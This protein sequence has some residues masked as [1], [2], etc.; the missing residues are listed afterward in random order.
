M[1]RHLLRFTSS[2]LFFLLTIT[3]ISA[4][5]AVVEVALFY[6]PTCPH[7]HDIID[8]YLPPLQERY[9]DALRIYYINVQEQSGSALFYDACSALKVP[10]EQCGGVPFMVIGDQYMIG[11]ADIPAR[12]ENLVQAGLAQGGQN[13]SSL[14]L[15]WEVLQ[16]QQATVAEEALS[17]DAEVA[18]SVETITWQERFSQDTLANSLAVVI[19]IALL[20]SVLAM[21][22]AGRLALKGKLA[23]WLSGRLV[24]IFGLGALSGATLVAFSIVLGAES[25]PLLVAAL[26]GLILLGVAVSFVR[27]PANKTRR[28]LIPPVIVSGLLVAGYMSYIEVGKVEAVCGLVGNCNTVQASAYASVFGVP[29]GVIGLLGYVLLFGAWALSLRSDKLARISQ[30]ALLSMALFGVLFSI[31]LTF[32]EPFVIGASCAWCLTSALVMLTLL[33]LIAP[34]ALKAITGEDTDIQASPALKLR[35]RSS[36]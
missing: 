31:Y 12:M 14:P 13:L 2:L 30:I 20:L 23:P 9:G 15:L 8:N 3:T 28:M 5:S 33:W 18:L 21:L 36:H 32:L 25:L 35:R 29:V 24:Y 6:S 1:F 7:C 26:V 34:E 10:D 16:A 4:Q 22:E 27:I 19:L 11:S 17:A